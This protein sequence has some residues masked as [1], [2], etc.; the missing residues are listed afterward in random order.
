MSLATA[1]FP[2][3]PDALRAFA[4]CLLLAGPA[5]AQITPEP[6]S[7]GLA[8]RVVVDSGLA[9]SFRGLVEQRVK[10][11]LETKFVNDALGF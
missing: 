7:L 9:R 5:C 10:R 4:L 2:A 1:E 6:E 3:D 11:S 8:R